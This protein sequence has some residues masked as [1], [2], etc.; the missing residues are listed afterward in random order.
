MKFNTV[1]LDAIRYEGEVTLVRNC[2]FASML[3]AKRS[4][5][6]TQQAVV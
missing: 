2:L 4:A 6:E 5:S 3:E 1:G